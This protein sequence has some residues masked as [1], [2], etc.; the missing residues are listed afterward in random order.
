MTAQRP[1]QLTS[2]S[3]RETCAAWDRGAVVADVRSGRERRADG[4]LPGAIALDDLDARRGPEELILVCRDGSRAAG[5]ALDL[6]PLWRAPIMM[7]TGGYAAWRRAVL[8]DW[9]ELLIFEPTTDIS[10]FFRLLR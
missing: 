5:L 1:V 2:I 9:A 7:V 3:P 4:V 6:R 10:R 8:R